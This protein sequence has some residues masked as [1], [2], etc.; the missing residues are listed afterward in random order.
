MREPREAVT[1]VACLRRGGPYAIA[2]VRSEK[3][4]LHVSND[5]I[6]RSRPPNSPAVENLSASDTIYVTGPKLLSSV[7]Q[8]TLQRAQREFPYIGVD[9][10]YEDVSSEFYYPRTD[11]G[12]YLERG[13]PIMQFFNGT[14]PDYHRPSDDV[15]KLDIGK[16]TA[17]SKLSF[18]ALWLAA[19]N[20][21]RPTWDGILPQTLWWVK[22]RR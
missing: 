20:P 7:A 13:I 4:V 2:R 5:M 6:G 19:D 1:A 11:A 14:H 15:A 12:P 9:Q 3:L 8:A 22:P 21:A 17:V 10:R 18:G 16:I